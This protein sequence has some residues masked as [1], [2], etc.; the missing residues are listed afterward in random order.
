MFAT[1][2]AVQN[3]FARPDTEVAVLVAD[4]VRRAGGSSSRAGSASRACTSLI[5]RLASLA[6]SFSSVCAISLSPFSR[7]SRL[8]CTLGDGTLGS[9][10][11]SLGTL[12]S[13]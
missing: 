4:R 7:L 3:V 8:V 6:I 1:A 9:G 12:V 13:G 5:A 2:A 10:S 11:L